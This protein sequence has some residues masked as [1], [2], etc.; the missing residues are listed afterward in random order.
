MDSDTGSAGASTGKSWE[1]TS[2]HEGP[3]H[4]PSPGRKQK[5]MSRSAGV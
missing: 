2:E 1:G 4:D 3:A 5:A